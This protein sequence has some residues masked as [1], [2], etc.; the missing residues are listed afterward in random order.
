MSALPELQAAVG[1][2]LGGCAACGPDAPLWALFSEPQALAERR[3]AAYRRNVIGN[4]RATL[5]STYPVLAQLV[6]AKR[7]RELADCYIASCPSCNGDLNAYGGE[8]AALLE[9]Y[10][11]CGELPYLTDIARLE[12]ALLVAYG[13]AD[14]AAFDLAALAAVPAEAQA[15]LRLEVWAGGALIESAW[16]LVDIW[17]AHQLGDVGRDAALAVIDIV[18]SPAKICRALV[19]RVDG[20]VSV[21]ALSVGEAVFLRALQSGQ[22]LAQ[23]IA[24]ALSEDPGFKPAAT[25]QGFVADRVLS[26][27]RLDESR[28]GIPFRGDTK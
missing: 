4:W 23:G 25:L 18:P 21:R 26:G 8:M 12:W 27:F 10:A 9:T 20:R 11:W 22:S 19:V 5:A 24:V 14:A 2:A 15:A 16:P 1:R 13:A 28:H 17:L 6:G 7:F 3:L